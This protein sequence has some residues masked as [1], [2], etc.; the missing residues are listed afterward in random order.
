MEEQKNKHICKFCKKSF[1][2]GRSLGGHIRSH[3]PKPG[4]ELRENPK[5]TWRSVAAADHEDH[6]MNSSFS[7]SSN[8]TGNPKSSKISSQNQGKR[9]S[10]GRNNSQS[11]VSEVVEAEQE[12]QEEVVVAMCLIMLSRDVGSWGDV[13]SSF[14]AAATAAADQGSNSKNRRRRREKVQG[15]VSVSADKNSE[16]AVSG[17]QQKGLKLKEIEVN[18]TG[19]GSNDQNSKFSES[20]KKREKIDHVGKSIK[21]ESLASGFVKD[22][23]KMKEY[24]VLENGFMSND[25]NKQSSESKRKINA[26]SSASGFVKKS[27]KIVEFEVSEH[28]ISSYDQK[29]S[30]HEIFDS[31]FYSSMSKR[32]KFECTTCN[33]VFHSY[34]ALGGHKASHKKHGV[35]GK[36]SPPFPKLGPETDIGGNDIVL[37]PDPRQQPQS[38][39]QQ[40]HELVPEVGA[41][42]GSSPSKKV[43]N[44]HECPICYRVF[45]SGQ[46]LGGHKRSHL[47]VTSNGDTNSKITEAKINNH[48]HQTSRIDD[49]V[50]RLSSMESKVVAS[51]ALLV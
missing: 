47:L 42:I 25:Q 7:S 14:A 33:K 34:Q 24:D 22:S 38:Q 36:C 28:G 50:E 20:K 18:I 5:K 6:T 3:L 44:K 8:E 26:Q 32:S 13:S 48:I 35:G 37:S 46:A 19:F 43:V 40:Q 2:C 4:Y 15:N 29:S 23:V 51:L 31:E 16:S 41:I 17:Y 10:F 1:P 21:M 45:P 12:E 9:S 39:P 27:S 30:D 11:S 49:V